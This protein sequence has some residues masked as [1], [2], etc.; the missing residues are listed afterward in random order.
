M[1]SRN[2]K[3]RPHWFTDAKWFFGI[4]FTV[5]L[6]IVLVLFFFYKVTA[7]KPAIET[8]TK[9]IAITFSPLGLDDT[10]EIEIL[11]RKVLYSYN[12]TARPINGL[13]LTIDKEDLE[14][15]TPREIRLNF[16]KKIAELLYFDQ[17]EELR[18]MVENNEV[19]NNIEILESLSFLSQK[20]HRNISGLLLYFTFITFLFAIPFIFFSKRFGRLGNP[21]LVIFLV[22]F[23]GVITFLVLSTLPQQEAT[24]AI[25]NIQEM[26]GFI[27]SSLLPPLAEDVTRYYILFLMV[28]FL[29]IFL[30]IVG[31]IVWKLF[32]PHHSNVISKDL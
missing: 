10:T 5:S 22:N 28:G 27:L 17:A 14:G 6:I 26:I 30:A 29:M 23:P 18:E 9:T 1:S 3:R 4:F 16:Y 20:T 11:K 25:E 24:P 13:N 19:R 32:I 12:E 15:K 31:K 7:E 21:G 8:M 2:R